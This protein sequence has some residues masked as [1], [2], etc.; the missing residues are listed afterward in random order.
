M[1]A[2]DGLGEEP[3]LILTLEMDG[4]SFARFDELRRRHFPPGRN[5]VP[6]HVTLFNRLPA[7]RA[8]EIKGLLREVAAR[9]KPIDVVVGEAKALERGVAIAL[10]SPQLHALRETLAA[11]WRPFLAEPDLAA[12]RPHVTIQNNVS[13]AEAR[14]TQRQVSAGRLPHSLRG[15]GLHLWRYREGFW[16]DVQLFRFA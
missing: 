3:P 4:E 6:A 12:F 5:L 16:E 1:A 8:R 14:T 15:V 9:Q 11:E 2:G 13:A 10:R 7:G